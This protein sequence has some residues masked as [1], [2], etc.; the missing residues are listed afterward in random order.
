MTS[1]VLL[2]LLLFYINFEI[3]ALECSH[4]HIF[5]LVTYHALSPYLSYISSPFDT[6]Y[7]L[8][9]IFLA[10]TKSNVPKK[11]LTGDFTHAIL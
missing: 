1:M 10:Q 7:G 5:P 6:V 9:L 8:K 3:P 4:S 2:Q 11:P